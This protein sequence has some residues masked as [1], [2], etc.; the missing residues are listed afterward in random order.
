MITRKTINVPIYD[1]TIYVNIFD[2]WEEVSKYYTGDENDEREGFLLINDSNIT[3]LK[4]FI[5]KD[6][7]SCIIHEITH[8][9]NIIFD[10]IGHTSNRYNDEPEAYLNQYLYKRIFEVYH[11]H[12]DNTK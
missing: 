5:N 3:K 7:P 11:R 1:F 12:I 9:K 10:I 4:L 2:K 8:I 6:C